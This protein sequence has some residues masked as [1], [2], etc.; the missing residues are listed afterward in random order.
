[1]TGSD[2]LAL[3]ALRVIQELHEFVYAARSLP[4]WLYVPDATA[5]TDSPER[6]DADRRLNRAEATRDRVDR[7]AVGPRSNSSC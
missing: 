1:M 2:H 5:P 6:I 7:E 4:G 3:G